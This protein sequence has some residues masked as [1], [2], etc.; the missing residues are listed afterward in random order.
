MMDEDTCATNFM[1][2]DSR[3]QALV[4]SDKE[5]ITP[6]IAR[7]RDLYAKRGVSTVL[8]VGGAGDYFDVADTVVM[9]DSYQCVDRTR[10][11]K[12]ISEAHRAAHP[13]SGGAACAPMDAGAGPSVFA[14]GSVRCVQA[15]AALGCGGGKVATR[16]IGRLTYGER[17]VAQPPGP[18][19]L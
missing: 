17:E 4:A 10:E 8:V 11:A 19:C 1:I 5:P 18:S 14:P 15:A 7:V 2:R 9:M 16:G 6:F 3:M 13:S 12:A